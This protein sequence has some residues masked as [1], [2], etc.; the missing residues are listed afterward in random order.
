MNPVPTLKEISNKELV[1]VIG[2]LRCRE[3][4][5]LA[6][7]VLYLSELDSRQAYREAGNS[8]LFT[9][10]TENLG[11]SE[12]SAFRRVQAAR[13]LSK[14]P[15]A[16]S[17]LKH[18]ELTLEGLA[19]LNKVLTEENAESVIS[20]AQ[21]KSVKE[22]EVLTVKLGATPK[23]VKREKVRVIKAKEE[24][25]LFAQT[26]APEVAE[27]HCY[28]ISFEADEEFMKLFNEVKALLPGYQGSIKAVFFK[29]LQEYQ[30]RTSPEERVKRRIERKAARVKSADSRKNPKCIPRAVK[31]EVYLRDQGRC[32]FR[33]PDGK[34]CST[35]HNLEYDHVIARALGGDNTVSNTRLMCRSHN[36]LMAERLFGV[37]FMRKFTG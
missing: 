30:K 23:R 5:C 2:N 14:H 25:A 26:S 24:G 8:S 35:T 28:E 6:E 4:E 33:S 13:A 16:Y 3:R 31:D 11:Y 20:Q 10:C 15:D 21:G 18:G 22:I 36:L 32:T 37:E 17:K 34:R 12:A 27:K 9:F 1:A 7:V 29:L 19:Q